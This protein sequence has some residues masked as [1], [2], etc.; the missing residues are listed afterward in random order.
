MAVQEP[1]WCL[2]CR[3][4]PWHPRL[5]A[6]GVWEKS[7]NLQHHP[8]P[9]ILLLQAGETYT[10]SDTPAGLEAGVVF[11]LWPRTSAGPLK[12][13]AGYSSCNLAPPQPRLTQEAPRCICTKAFPRWMHEPLTRLDLYLV[14]PLLSSFPALVMLGALPGGVPKRSASRI[15]VELEERPLG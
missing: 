6:L 9:I 13:A 14:L 2:G 10:C 1:S 11:C 5:P 12:M 8:A 15:P 4:V 7:Q 3:Q